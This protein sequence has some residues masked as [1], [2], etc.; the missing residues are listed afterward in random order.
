MLSK[1]LGFGLNAQNWNDRLTTIPG[2]LPIRKGEQVIGAIGICGGVP[3]ED[4]A[5][6]QAII[7]AF[8]EG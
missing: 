5:L 3:D 7:E 6:C 8:N 4:V 1:A 2:G